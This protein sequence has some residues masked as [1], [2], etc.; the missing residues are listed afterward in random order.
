MVDL[1]PVF[2]A[3]RAIGRHPGRV[4][5]VWYHSAKVQSFLVEMMFS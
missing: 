3:E 5:A 1:L 4:S 2:L